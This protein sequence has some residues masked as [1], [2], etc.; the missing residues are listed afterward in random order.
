MVK[1]WGSCKAKVKFTDEKFSEIKD[2][3]LRKVETAVKKAV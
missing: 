3:F 2:E 1:R